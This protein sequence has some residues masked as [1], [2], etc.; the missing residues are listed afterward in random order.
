MKKTF[1]FRFS[2]VLIIGLVGFFVITSQY[3]SIQLEQQLEDSHHAMDYAQDLITGNG[4][5]QVI[6]DELYAGAISLHAS[7]IVDYVEHY[8]GFGCAIFK[9]NE[10]VSTTFQEEGSNELTI[11]SQANDEITDLVIDHGNEFEGISETIG[12][13]RLVYYKP[14]FGPNNESVGMVSVFKDYSVFQSSFMFFGII[15][16]TTIFALGGFLILMLYVSEKKSG[17]LLKMQTD[18]ISSNAGLIKS[19]SQTELLSIVAENTQQSVIITNNSD[20]IEWVNIAFESTFGYKASEVIGKKIAAIIGGPKTD[21]GT[22]RAIDEA[23]FK[24]KEPIDVVVLNYKKDKTEFWTKAYITPVFDENGELARYVTTSTDITNEKKIQDLLEQSE[25]NFRQIA[26]TMTDVFYLYNIEEKK[27]EFMSDNSVEVMGA[28]PQFYYDGKKYTDKFVHSAD[29]ELLYESNTKIDRGEAYDIEYRV[30]IEGETKWLRERSFPIIDDK[31]RVSKNSGI[32]SDITV[33]KNISKEIEQNFLSNKIMAELGTKITEEINVKKIIQFTHEKL[34]ELMD[35]ESFAIG[36]VDRDKNELEFPY[37]IDHFNYFEKVSYSL[38]ANILATI[39]I[40]SEKDVIIQD[41][42]NEIESLTGE[43]LDKTEGELP[44]SVIYLPVFSKKEVIGVIT[45]QSSKKNAYT[46]NQVELLRGLSVYVSNALTMAQDFESLEDQVETRTEE[47]FSQKEKVE[48]AYNDS[49]LL[50]QIGLDIASSIEFEEVFEK[51]YKNL[52]KLIDAEIF[53]IRMLDSELG[54]VDYKYEIESGQREESMRISMSDKDN[55]TVW[56][57]ENE[58]EIFIND[59]ITEY[60]NYVKQIRVAA[61]EMPASL[62]FCPILYKEAVIGVITVQSLKKHAYKKRALNILQ[63][64]SS[65]CGI[66]YANSQRF[67][68]LQRKIEDKS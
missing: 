2:A 31:R 37:F 36:I 12:K 56:C 61:G 19:K 14:L 10:R 65:Y 42:E 21:I 24:K 15:V 49:Q 52:N 11:G 64:L 23:I 16:G 25:A 1:L 34:V 59:N 27:Y 55:Y 5:F 28:D 43:P 40:K 44:K 18:L 30:I 39:C 26:D 48:M 17:R 7:P 63:T 9:G 60:K 41:F 22:I 54:E 66:A 8:T 68:M 6:N 29:K 4:D 50:G 67:D 32:V 53:G 20:V 62:I 38:E 47:V 13:S 45:V 33:S 57:I 46:M 35:A 3:K 58:K 51:I